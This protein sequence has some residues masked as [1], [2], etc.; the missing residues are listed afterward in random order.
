MDI[1]MVSYLKL[2]GRGFEGLPEAIN[3]AGR[4]DQ[5]YH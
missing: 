1:Q 5:P 4:C 3:G 2:A